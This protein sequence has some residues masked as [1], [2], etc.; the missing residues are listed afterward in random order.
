MVDNAP[1]LAVPWWRPLAVVFTDV[2]E[3]MADL[4]VVIAVQRALA[5]V[6][7]LV[8]VGAFALMVRHTPF[9]LLHQTLDALFGPA[10]IATADALI[11]GT[12]G[13]ASLAVLC[14]FSGTMAMVY[15]QRRGGQ[16]VSPA[17]SAIVVMACFFV[18]TNPDNDM[19]WRGMFSMNRGLLLAFMVSVGG[20]GLFVRLSDVKR[21]QLPL[22]AAGHDPVVR[23]ILTQMPAAMLTIIIFGL[24][25]AGLVAIGI[26]DLHGAVHNVMILPF[27][28]A[29]NTL[30]LGLLYTGLSQVLWFF[31]A[32]GPN[33]LF[34]IEDAI[35]APAGVA[36][37]AAVAAGQAP[38][39]VLTKTFFDVFT[40]MG[41]S[42]STL[43]L[44]AAILHASRDSG[45]RRLALMALLPALCNVNEPL[46]FGLPMVMNPVYLI[47]FLLVPL[48]Q[49]IAAHTATLLHL[50]PYTLP[51]V[52]WTT[53][54]LL[55]GYAATGSLAGS[56]M[57]AFN[58]GLGMALY[59]PF[60]RMSDALRERHGRHIL[61][62]LL[63]TASGNELGPSGRKCI[64]RPG[65][66]GRVA[67]S[68]ANDLSA[69]LARDDEV[70]MEYQPQIGGDGRPHGAEAL[71]RWHH[72]AYG[73][74]A[75]PIAVALA[76][77]TGIIDQLGMLVLHRAC[78]RRV[79]WTGL[80]PDD[81]IM[82]VNVAPRQLLN[83]RFDRDVLDLLSRTGLAPH[84]LELELTESTVLL[85][86]KRTVK[87][88]RRLRAA[89]VRVAIDDFG[90]GH[91]S[92][93]YLRDFPVDTVKIDR[94]L[95]EASHGDINQHIMRSIVELSRS[96][97]ITTVVEG[98]ERREQFERFAELGCQVFQGY[99]FSR[100]VSAARCLEV[101]AGWDEHADALV[102]TAPAPRTE[103]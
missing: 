9:P 33:L 26:S 2:T 50:V 93:R 39:Y 55:N 58:L 103:A 70:F 78:A 40:R 75:P 10:W 92:L 94:S 71:L 82:S 97:D 91:A 16:L 76:E 14:A 45:N 52:V 85:P 13:I 17:M 101:V 35:L 60:V 5:L 98:V 79:A 83:P 20:S 80:V 102:Q 24:L 46:L 56:L 23:D 74:I 41:G 8:T 25:R 69:A 30:G 27:T 4:P 28:E 31:G 95:T 38:P 34:P 68:L 15:N 64:D 1:P 49:T 32:H 59:L 29:G 66:Q 73:R 99:L 63:H 90:M 51:D 22:K 67:T 88:L 57:Q 48:A 81:F 19:S 86:D 100:P 84:L 36:N 47:P 87:A 65:E 37:A 44:I 61:T 6:L 42:G 3:R 21:L 18:V 43:C 96:L 12:F 72:P 89:G 11:S 7:P 54:P 53:P 62:E 77:D